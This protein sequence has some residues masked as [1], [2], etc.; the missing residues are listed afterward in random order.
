MR[1]CMH[2]SRSTVT[3]IGDLI[4]RS[5]GCK[6]DCIVNHKDREHEAAAMSPM[7]GEQALLR[8][9]HRL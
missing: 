4:A 3:H 7:N 6:L 1:Y 2:D 8:L 9:L 5:G